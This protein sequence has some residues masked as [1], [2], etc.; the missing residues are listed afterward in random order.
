MGVVYR[1]VDET[2]DDVV[3]LKTL[4]LKAGPDDR[5][6]LLFKTEFWAM[7]RLRHPNL[8]EVYDFGRLEYGIP[9][10]TME[11]IEGAD[12]VDLSGG[13]VCWMTGLDLAA[14]GIATGLGPTLVVAAE[15]AHGVLN[16]GDRR[17]FPLFGEGAAAVLLS[18][19]DRGGVISSRFF[20]DGNHWRY[21][22]APRAPSRP[23][24]AGGR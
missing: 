23:A 11:L 21:L 17:T 5:R 4:P 19:A 16:P 24:P 20:A 14:R 6:L 3:A 1:V 10:F 18:P 15:R 22:W 13:G 7:T 8:P 9:Y 12:V 2:S